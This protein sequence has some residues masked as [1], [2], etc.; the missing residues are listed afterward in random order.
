MGLGGLGSGPSCAASASCVASGWGW[1]GDE[2]GVGREAGAVE[3]CARP[4]GD[5]R[6]GRG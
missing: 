3:A 2:V 5:G 6:A 4:E 1:K